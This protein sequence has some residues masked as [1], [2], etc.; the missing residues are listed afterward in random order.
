MYFFF[1]FEKNYV[2]LTSSQCINVD[3]IGKYKNIYFG[4]KKIPIISH[5]NKHLLH[6]VLPG[7]E[8]SFLGGIVLGDVGLYVEDGGAEQDVHAGHVD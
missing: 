8:R 1:K 7:E 5:P 3:T 4:E 6:K 2:Y